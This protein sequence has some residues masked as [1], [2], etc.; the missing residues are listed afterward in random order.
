MR[1]AEA[2]DRVPAGDRGLQLRVLALQLRVVP[3]SVAEGEVAALVPAGRLDVEV[4]PELV[5]VQLAPRR[6]ASAASAA[7]GRGPAGARNPSP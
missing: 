7:T 6:R 1:V 3:E 4:D 2:V 5:A